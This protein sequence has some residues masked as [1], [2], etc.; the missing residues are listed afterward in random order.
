MDL[1]LHAYKMMI[2]RELFTGDV[3]NLAC[4][5]RLLEVTPKNAV[6]FLSD[7]AHFRLST[8]NSKLNIRY[9]SASISCELHERPLHCENV[10]EQWTASERDVNI[11]RL[12]SEPNV[13]IVK[14]FRLRKFDGPAVHIIRLSM[15]IMR[16]MFRGSL[17]SLE[18]VTCLFL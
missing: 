18:V 15:K 1:E 6:L 3:Q 7:Q 9:R 5:Q 11:M 8:C 12:V 2:A 14:I 16:E 13:M 4:S 17:I 10:N